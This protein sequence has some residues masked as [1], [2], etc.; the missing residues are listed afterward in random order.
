MLKCSDT[1]FIRSF[2]TGKNTNWSSA[3]DNI[4]FVVPAGSVKNNQFNVAFVFLAAKNM[5]LYD[6]SLVDDD[7]RSSAGFRLWPVSLHILYSFS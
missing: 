3:F 4:Q 2:K 1:V 6:I 5:L 7:I